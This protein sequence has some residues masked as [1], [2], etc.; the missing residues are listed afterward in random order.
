MS[1][2][3][4]VVIEEHGGVVRT[5]ITYGSPN[6]TPTSS[7]NSSPVLL[8]RSPSIHPKYPTLMQRKDS[9][10]Y[11]IDWMESVKVE[12]KVVYMEI[13]NDF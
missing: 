6:N 2:V 1:Q 3:S 8:T 9:F 5:V 11:K 12:N 4:N 7:P 10:D 13:D